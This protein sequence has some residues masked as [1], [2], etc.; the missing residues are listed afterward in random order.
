M[1][2]NRVNHPFLI[3]LY[4]P[5]GI[6]VPISWLNYY[7]GSLWVPPKPTIFSPYIGSVR[8]AFFF[9]IHLLLLIWI[10]IS[11][12]FS[13]YYIYCHWCSCYPRFGQWEPLQML[14]W[15]CDYPHD[16]QSTSSTSC[17]KLILQFLNPAFPPKRCWFLL[18][19]KGIEKPS[20][21]CSLLL[22]CA[23]SQPPEWMER[24]D[25]CM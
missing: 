23:R 2:W 21:V 11:V 6:C 1:L 7:D 9:P 10:Q 15:S 22:V 4:P 16:S 17:S 3:N 13:D 18:V 20:W 14:L 8:K 25:I 12:L 19:Q 5:F 24:Q